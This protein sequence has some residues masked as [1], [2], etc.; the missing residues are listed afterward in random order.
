MGRYCPLLAATVLSVTS[1]Q[2][3]TV[4]DDFNDNSRDPLIW[5]APE[6][7]EGS[8]RFTEQNQRLEFSA[9]A[10]APENAVK[11]G[12]QVYPTYDE[13]WQVQLVVSMDKANMT[14]VNQTGLINIEVGTSVHFDNWLEAGYAAGILPGVSENQAIIAMGG[15]AAVPEG[16]GILDFRTLPEAIGIRL[17]YDPGLRIIRVYYDL[18]V[19]QT[20]ED[21]ILLESYTID[22]STIPGARALN[23]GM[24]SFDTFFLE[25]AGHSEAVAIAT[26]SAWADD[27]DFH[28]GSTAE[29]QPG[30]SF[31]DDFNDD[32]RDVSWDEPVVFSG[33]PSLVEQNGHLEFISPTAAGDAETRQWINM[34]F[35]PQYNQAFEVSTEVH[36][37]PEA[38]TMQ[39]QVG[40]LE[41]QIANDS[42]NGDVLFSMGALFDEGARQQVLAV[43][44]SEV[45]PLG[46]NPEKIEFGV[47]PEIVGLRIT[48]APETALMS[49]YTD[50]DGDRFT[51]TW[52]LFAEFT[53]DG[54]AQGTAFP[55]DWQ[56]L[57]ED[58][59]RIELNAF[60]EGT[61]IE[62]GEAY[63]E[64]FSF[65]SAA[66]PAGYDHWSSAIADEGMRDAMADASGNG[67][68][69][70]LQYMYGLGP[71]DPDTDVQLTLELE[72]GKPVLT[73]GVN[74]SATDYILGYRFTNALGD[75]WL[76]GSP[77]MAE[78]VETFESNGRTYRKLTFPPSA[79]DTFLQLEV[80]PR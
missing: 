11:Q 66:S 38:M 8:G 29:T 20:E 67:I 58:R 49:C 48:W 16:I 56:M 32:S 14:T 78:A 53:L 50:T 19:D 73:H 22:G 34:D 3:Q 31:H 63:Y 21:W 57:P 40:V 69:N 35:W 39:D 54:S 77:D 52:D 59:F 9:P 65:I 62:S 68:P 1:A 10:A 74:E 80:I 5:W 43:S 47:L 45:D 76:W 33:E 17:T 60:A 71:M 23:W 75:P 30:L 24:T 36:C 41:M 72:N 37:L 46:E 28:L 12:L 7:L 25:V 18:D 42:G 51:E 26:G 79:S 55:S 61:A 44:N 6:V 27:F 4:S 64:D 13:A 2:A 15:D 70:L